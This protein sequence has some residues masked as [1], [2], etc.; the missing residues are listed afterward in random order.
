LYWIISKISSYKSAAKI[1]SSKKAG[2]F[3]SQMR[4][5]FCLKRGGD[6]AAII[7]QRFEKK[8]ME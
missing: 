2:G 6:R 7:Y 8:G 4:V 5:F 1:N 3:L